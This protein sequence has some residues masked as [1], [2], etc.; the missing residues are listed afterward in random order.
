M[1]NGQGGLDTIFALCERPQFAR[2]LHSWQRE[3]R[4]SLNP[5]HIHRYCNARNACFEPRCS[6]DRVFHL[7]Q[8]LTVAAE[9]HTMATL[10]VFLLVRFGCSAVERLRGGPWLQLQS[11]ASDAYNWQ[12]CSWQNL[13]LLLMCLCTRSVAVKLGRIACCK[14]PCIVLLF[15]CNAT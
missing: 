4:I 2:K 1:G 12:H 5:G 11:S 10:G 13:G 14:W 8:K 9:A 6:S 7:Q 15:A 3:D